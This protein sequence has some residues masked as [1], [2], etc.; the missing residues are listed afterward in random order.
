GHLPK[1]N[2]P[3]EVW[4]KVFGYVC[5]SQLARISMASPYFKAVVEQMEIWEKIAN[6]AL[7]KCKAN[8]KNKRTK[9]DYGRVIFKSNIICENCYKKCTN[10]FRAALPVNSSVHKKSINMCLAC[11]Q[12]HYK[13]FPEFDSPNDSKVKCGGK[14]GVEAQRAFRKR[15]I[16]Q[17]KEKYLGP[18]LARK[19][20]LKNSLATKGLAYD[21][22]NSY[23]VEYIVD[24][25]WG[26]IDVVKWTVA[27]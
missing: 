18:M 20:E 5:P 23:H 7:P 25:K 10:G 3:F 6:R 14:V 1:H 26:V 8:P 15:E 11:R 9:T 13:E 21:E 19:R 4:D 17:E 16:Q 22:N 27:G 12:K 2:L 24:G